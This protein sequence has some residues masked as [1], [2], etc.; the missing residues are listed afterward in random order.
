MILK[1]SFLSYSALFNCNIDTVPNF[2]CS[3]TSLP[4]GKNTEK[5]ADLVPPLEEGSGVLISP[6]LQCFHKVAFSDEGLFLPLY[7]LPFRFPRHCQMQRHCLTKNLKL[8]NSSLKSDLVS[9]SGEIWQRLTWFTLV[10]S[11]SQSVA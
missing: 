7:C 8:F 10:D 5:L 11:D 9:V 4:W 2:H 3:S 6:S 1:A